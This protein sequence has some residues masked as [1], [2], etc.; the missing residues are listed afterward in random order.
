LNQIFDESS[1]VE[2]ISMRKGQM[3]A[4]SSFI[5]PR[6]NLIPAK[7]DKTEI[8]AVADYVLI[9]SESDWTLL[10]ADKKTKN[11]DEYPGC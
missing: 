5:S 4:Y 8:S 10:K 9:Q 7:L 3:P 2:I 11:C 1:V 6:G